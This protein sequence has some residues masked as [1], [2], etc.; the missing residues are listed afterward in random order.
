MAMDD[1]SRKSA[2]KKTSNFTRL[3]LQV[4]LAFRSA[5]FRA[6]TFRNSGIVPF[7]GSLPCYRDCGRLSCD[8]DG[9][10]EFALPNRVCG[11]IGQSF[12]LGEIETGNL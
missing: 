12:S 6:F 8:Q 3:N 7:K 4:V 11:G 1:V 5:V 10:A 2:I 9:V